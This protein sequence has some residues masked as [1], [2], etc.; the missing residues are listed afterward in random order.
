MIDAAAQHAKTLGGVLHVRLG[1]VLDV[2]RGLVIVQRDC[3]FVVE[4]LASFTWGGASACGPPLSW[5][6]LARKRPKTKR[7]AV[8]PKPARLIG[9]PH[10]PPPGS[11]G[12]PRSNR[13]PPSLDN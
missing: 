13:K 1:F 4:Q 11:I 10:A 8:V 5:P 12:L 7:R 3:T 9:S 2:F 6:Q